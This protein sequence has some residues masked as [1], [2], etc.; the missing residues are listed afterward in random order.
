M[1]VLHRPRRLGGFL[2]VAALALLAVGQASAKTTLNVC[3]NATSCFTTVQAAV[4]AAAD[5]DRIKIAAGTYQGEISISKSITLVGAGADVT[6]ITR[7]PAS[8]P[9]VEV[10][11]IT[12]AP[13]T[14]VTIRALAVSGFAFCGPPEPIPCA[15]PSNGSAI[16]NGGDLRLQNVAV[17][18]TY[19][20]GINN[21]GTLTLRGTSV[22]ANLGRGV[23]GGVLNSATLTTYSSTIT[24]NGL[25]G[26]NVLGGGGGI[27]NNGTATI[28]DSVISD[29]SGG[30][31][32]GGI[33]N[34]GEMT[35]YSTTVSGNFGVFGA[36][37]SNY[38]AAGQLRLFDSQVTGNVAQDGG[39]GIENGGTASISDS[40]LAENTA[41][42]GAGIYNFNALTLRESTVT[43]N[44]ATTEGGGILNLGTVT[45]LDNIISGNTPDDCVGC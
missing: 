15:H 35:L 11:G 36:G 1:R 30:Q 25:S 13:G 21:G 6:V 19:G 44:H 38:F 18:N 31:H 45:L 10:S 7:D 37:I 26:I 23:G 20:R 3:T 29:N 43:D 16:V 32:G 4:D 17:T 34:A 2:G 41:D 9:T 12:T 40:R 8:D 22:S 33:Q 14:T 39:G 24:R 27:A 5:G 42:G 28:H